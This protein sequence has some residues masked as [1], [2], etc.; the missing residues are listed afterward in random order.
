MSRF[1][2]IEH[3]VCDTC[4]G[5]VTF[6]TCRE[7]GRL[8]TVRIETDLATALQKLA[9]EEPNMIRAILRSVDITNA[10]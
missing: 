3:A 5:E 9:N 7:C 2:V 4:N 8:G 10:L 6:P 1:A